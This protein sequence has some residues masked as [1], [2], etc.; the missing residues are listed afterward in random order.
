MA[1]WFSASAVA[2]TVSRLWQLGPAGA[3][4]LT[5]S[6]QL[7]FVVGAL[8]S[9]MLT[10]S[11]IWSARR[12]VQA[13]AVVAGLATLGVAIAPTRVVGIALR[14]VTGAALAG[15][16][17]PGMKIVAGWFR[18]GRGLAIG[19]MVGALTLGS[20]LPHLARW[21]VPAALWRPVLGAAGLA[22]FAGSALMALVPHDGPF[23]ALAPNFSWN[24]VPRILRERA[25]TLA[26]LG[27]CGH[28]WELYAMWTWIAV[29]VAESERARTHT[30]PA[31]GLPAL[32]TFAVV[33]SGAIGCW[34]GGKRRSV[35]PHARHERRDG[36]V[37]HLCARG[38]DAVR[39]P[40]RRAAAAA[41][42]VGCDGGGR[43]GSVLRL[44][45]RARAAGARGHGA[46]A[47][48]QP[49][50]PAHQS[51]DLSVAVG[52]AAHR[53]ALEYEPARL[54]AGGRGVGNADV[55]AAPGG[56]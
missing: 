35:G 7:G 38:R 54:G 30:D 37:G 8:V 20:A 14:L 47:A 9:A 36:A 18:E 15:V 39:A 41:A 21:L 43:L 11:D 51:D 10:L 53:V 17:P 6:V 13:S 25:V 31:A 45:E 24:A 26:N 33:G 29:F 3:A 16:Y 56:D 44:G 22:A 55:A 4:W 49:G 52:R 1:P 12:L 32:V 19:I 50:V 40:A 34:L 2:P 5:I 46:H 27:Y 23:A 28:M 48:D 42:R